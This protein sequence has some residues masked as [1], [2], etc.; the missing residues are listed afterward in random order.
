MEN[1]NTT[2]KSKILHHT[3]HLHIFLKI[4]LQ[5]MEYLG[6]FFYLSIRI[7][8]IRL[9]GMGKGF[10]SV[11]VMMS[12]WWNIS[13]LSIFSLWDLNVE[14]VMDI[15]FGM[16]VNVWVT[17][18]QVPTVLI[19]ILVLYA[20]MGLNGMEQTV[21]NLVL[22]ASFCIYQLANANALPLYTGMVN[23]VYLVIF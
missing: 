1:I 4:L 6:L 18:Q 8:S 22:K 11:L 16:M 12:V 21:W 14:I 2:Q 10:C 15:R 19:R 23:C 13:H 7:L 3:I 9:I 17:V 20:K 5:F